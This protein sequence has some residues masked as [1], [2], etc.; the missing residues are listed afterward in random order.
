MTNLEAAIIAIAA[1][2]KSLSW[3]VTDAK[4]REDLL[5]GNMGDMVGEYSPELTEAIELLKLWEK[6]K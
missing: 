5:R 3:L 4:H 6:K 2:H 1:Y